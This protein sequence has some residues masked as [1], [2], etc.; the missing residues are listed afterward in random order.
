MHRIVE[1]VGNASNEIPGT[2]CAKSACSRLSL[3]Y[4]HVAHQCPVD[5]FGR[6]PQHISS[7]SRSESPD[8]M[9]IFCKSGG[10]SGPGDN[11]I[12][13][14][15]ML[16]QGEVNH[17]DCRGT[18]GAVCAIDIRHPGSPQGLSEYVFAQLNA[19]AQPGRELRLARG[20]SVHHS[21]RLTAGAAPVR[22]ASR[23]Q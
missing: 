21:P 18:F 10:R 6:D 22:L 9:S 16:R 20:A 8:A 19:C 14:G 15:A 23:I 5:L 11:R 7:E 3:S 12:T 1:P 13:H 17:L 4:Q 2:A